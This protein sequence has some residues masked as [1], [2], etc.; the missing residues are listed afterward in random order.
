M[1]GYTWGVW[2][3]TDM[4]L[5]RDNITEAQAHEW[6]RSWNEDVAPDAKPNIFTVCRRPVGDWQIYIQDGFYTL[7]KG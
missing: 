4:S 7:S 5:H 6:V 3:N 1:S 2:C